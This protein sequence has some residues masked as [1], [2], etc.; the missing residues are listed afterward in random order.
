[1]S[2]LGLSRATSSAKADELALS[3]SE[4]DGS[5]VE[6]F[7]TPFLTISEEGRYDV[8][9]VKMPGKLTEM[10][11][12][13]T[14]ISIIGYSSPISGWHDHQCVTVEVMRDLVG[15]QAELKCPWL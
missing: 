8:D 11:I 10:S 6:P 7:F 2:K 13:S 14:E 3:S 12:Y 1:M 15:L 9:G 5:M 4:R